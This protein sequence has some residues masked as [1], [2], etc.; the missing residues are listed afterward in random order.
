MTYQLPNVDELVAQ[1]VIEASNR[2][3]KSIND[4]TPQEWDAI[5][6]GRCDNTAPLPHNADGGRNE[7]RTEYHKASSNL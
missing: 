4:A 2:K 7:A 6:A 5:M 1:L 3:R